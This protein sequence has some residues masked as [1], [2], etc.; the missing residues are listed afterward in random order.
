VFL[1]LGEL[2]FD[3]EGLHA[4]GDERFGPVVETR[5]RGL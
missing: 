1:E 5:V 4:I 3:H 2:F